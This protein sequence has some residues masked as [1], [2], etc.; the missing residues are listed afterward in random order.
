M[1]EKQSTINPPRVSDVLEVDSDDEEIKQQYRIEVEEEDDHEDQNYFNS[2]LS[3]QHEENN[4]LLRIRQHSPMRHSRN[5][6]SQNSSVEEEKF[7]VGESSRSSVRATQ[8]ID[9]NRE[10]TIFM[11]PTFTVSNN[12]GNPQNRA[13]V[14]MDLE[15][16][17]PMLR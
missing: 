9:L 3:F 15:E 10:D 1:L 11:R 5:D 7:L 12:S 16:S 17:F 4:L 8:R 14:G 6:S 2:N 13:S